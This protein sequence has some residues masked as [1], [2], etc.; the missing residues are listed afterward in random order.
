MRSS[1]VSDW[2]RT[3]ARTLLLS[4][5]LG[6]A[7][8][9]LSLHD[10]LPSR[11]PPATKAPAPNS[12]LILPQG[13][14][15]AVHPNATAASPTLPMTAH[16]KPASETMAPQMAHKTTP[17]MTTEKMAAPKMQAHQA[18][19]AKTMAQSHAKTHAPT[20]TESAA[21]TPAAAMER[22]ARSPLAAYKIHPGD[23]IRI[24]ILDH[25]DAS[26]RAFIAEDGSI[27][28]PLVGKIIA[29][30]M[31]VVELRHLV[32]EE[33][34]RRFIV[35]PRVNVEVIKYRAFFVLGQV[36]S[37]GSYEF[38]VNIDVRQAVAIAGGFTR[39]ADEEAISITRDVLGHNRTFDAAK[40][41]KVLPG[42][43]VEVRRRWF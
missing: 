25:K 22:P 28:M 41:A 17:K 12:S 40:H 24:T 26:V 7:G 14:P 39:R 18:D 34:N 11:S 15:K 36:K 23:D 43:V 2:T 42:D 27:E 13:L 38:Q 4:A 32:T 6:L 10:L 30:G 31:T 9:G 21:E 5:L 35:N 29:G 37:P 33:L 20:P 3:S 8:C 1:N 16:G 19:S